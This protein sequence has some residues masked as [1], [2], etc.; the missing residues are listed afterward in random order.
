MGPSSAHEYNGGNGAQDPRIDIIPRPL[1]EL[2]LDCDA[3]AGVAD[4]DAYEANTNRREECHPAR[5]NTKLHSESSGS[6]S[7]STEV[8]RPAQTSAPLTTSESAHSPPLEP[9]VSNK[10]NLEETSTAC[11]GL[12]PV[13]AADIAADKVKRKKDRAREAKRQRTKNKKARQREELSEAS[14]AI[15]LSWSER[16]GTPDIIRTDVTVEQLGAADG[17]RKPVKSDVTTLAE[18]LSDGLRVVR[19]DGEYV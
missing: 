9:T 3:H 16:H 6:G 5:L 11:K 1:H 2:T 10:R 7:L 18:G 17:I 19:W 12:Q 8:E 13:H 15:R 14:A 4:S